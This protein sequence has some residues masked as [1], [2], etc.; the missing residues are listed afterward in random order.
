[1]LW[2]KPSIRLLC[3][4]TLLAACAGPG[5]AGPPGGARMNAAAVAAMRQAIVNGQRLPFEI[6]PN[7]LTGARLVTAPEIL[8]ET[9][10]DNSPGSQEV[11]TYLRDPVA[12]QRNMIKNHEYELGLP[13]YRLYLANG[14]I[15]RS[16][17]RPLNNTGLTRY[18]RFTDI[19]KGY[20]M[21]TASDPTH[22][23]EIQTPPGVKAAEILPTW[24]ATTPGWGFRFV[25]RKTK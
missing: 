20:T 12:W 7:L 10:A 18:H 11:H 4:L 5:L 23:Y 15:I 24:P 13:Q 3:G 22:V 14:T 25:V 9:L 16:W 17:V 2:S 1:M 21:T 8:R 19:E 6:A